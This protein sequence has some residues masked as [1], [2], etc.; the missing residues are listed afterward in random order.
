MPS[1][2]EGSI[3]LLNYFI[4][5]YNLLLYCQLVKSCTFCVKTLPA[6]LASR[7]SLGK[8]PSQINVTKVQLL[9][10]TARRVLLYHLLVDIY[11]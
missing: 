8:S 5:W 4:V 2:L 7:V 9:Q 3:S 1:A 11:M 6:R 10:G